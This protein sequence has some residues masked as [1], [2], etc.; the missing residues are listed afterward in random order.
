MAIVKGMQGDLRAAHRLF[1]EAAAIYCA[2][3]GPTHDETTAAETRAAK[4]LAVA[5]MR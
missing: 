4:A 2:S 3:Y 1:D 5:E